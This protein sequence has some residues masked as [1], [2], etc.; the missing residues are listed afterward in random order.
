MAFQRAVKRDAKG[1]VA[2][3]G[4]GGSGKSM[5]GL[6]L[7]RLLAG[8]EGK[9]AAVDTE[10]GSLSKY[11]HTDSCGGQGVCADPSHFEFD[12]DE[13]FEFSPEAFLQAL[14]AAETN[15]YAVF[16][17]DSLSHFWMGA[18]GALEYVDM[19]TN[20]N[21]A[22]GNRDGMSGWKDFRPHERKMIDRM[23][24]SP[25]HVICTM[26][27]KND[28]AEVER[29]G[30]KT[31][32]KIGLA[33]V[34]RDGLE[35]EFDLVGL[36][37][38]D[39][40]L[41]IDKTRCSFYQGRM[42]TK[43]GARE[44]APFQEW[45]KGAKV[46]AGAGSPPTPAPAANAGVAGTCPPAAPAIEVPEELKAVVAGLNAKGGASIAFGMLKKELLEALPSTGGTEYVRILQKHGIKP[47]GPQQTTK[48]IEAL[49]EMWK[50]AQWAK[51][52]AAKATRDA[53]E[54][55]EPEQIDML[56]D[57]I[58]TATEAA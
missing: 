16:L 32:V 56:A 41:S 34:Q 44:F 7:A 37:D 47:S 1:R 2:L 25:C 18:G 20:R 48:M 8:P 39:N 11:A 49:V 14:D 53:Q 23:I 52:S 36:M 17:V 5:T 12:V 40:S 43:P 30:K 54:A 26:R 46:A 10:H 33:P 55:P 6:I 31:R 4:P 51:E 15:G 42:L 57:P 45:L 24:A 13:F 19:A 50:L 9:I 22:K 35:Y 28:Y 21:N 38:D 58:P 3:I 27:T 29:N